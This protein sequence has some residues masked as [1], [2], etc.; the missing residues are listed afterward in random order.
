[1]QVIQNAIDSEIDFTKKNSTTWKELNKSEALSN[2][3]TTHCKLGTYKMT[4]MKCD[5][6]AC[7]FHL[8]RRLSP[9]EWSDLHA[10]PDAKLSSDGSK[11]R[12]VIVS[13]HDF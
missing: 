4:I 3:L 13:S 10:F 1:M 11:V 6:S 12:T 9:E 2:F 7:K 5:S 8:P